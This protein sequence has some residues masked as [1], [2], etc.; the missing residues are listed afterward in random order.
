[1][2]NSG[3]ENDHLCC[4]NN[5]SRGGQAL[6]EVTVI[7]L[8]GVVTDWEDSTRITPPAADVMPGY[9]SALLTSV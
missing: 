3:E 1:M 7:L 4:T 8:V 5:K 9:A 2:E 6:F